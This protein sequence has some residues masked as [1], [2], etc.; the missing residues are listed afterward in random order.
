MKRI[1]N[2]SGGKDST[3]LLHLMLERGLTPDAVVM[4]CSEWDFPEMEE[5]AQL[6]EKKT[7]L[8]INRVYPDKPLTYYFSEHVKTRGL[9]AGQKGYG[10]P[11]ARL[12]WCTRLKVQAINQ[13]LKQTFFLE[14]Y[15]QFIGFAVGEEKRAARSPGF[16]YPLIDWNYDEKDCLTLCRQLGYNWGGL[17]DLFDRVSCFCCPLQSRRDLL[18]LKRHRPEL[19]KYMLLMDKKLPHSDS[20]C[21][22]FRDGFSLVQ[23]DSTLKGK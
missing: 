9:S 20:L 5:H 23:I 21:Y 3:A 10:W 13:F 22:Q 18:I 2:F 12:R 1:L 4:F 17:Y 8:K 16:F 15:D 19:Y 6:V 11:S 7:G 14:P